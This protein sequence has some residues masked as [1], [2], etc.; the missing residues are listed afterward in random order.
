MRLL[1]VTDIRLYREGLADALA[2]MDAVDEVVTAASGASAV[3]A[4]RSGH[5]DIALVDMGTPQALGTIRAL[6][7]ARPHL[8]VVALGI[9]DDP[10][11][12]ECAAA[13]I[14][15]Y[16]S[17]DAGLATLAEAIALVGRGEAPCPGRTAAL[18]LSHI[19][20]QSRVRETVIDLTPRER[21]VLDLVR[22]GLTNRQIA[23]ALDLQL[24]TV[25]NHVHNVLGKC[26][27]ST[28]GEVIATLPG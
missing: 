22:T 1:V 23:R 20:A 26:G 15:G 19:A 27:A 2:R 10:Q 18:L 11:A 8:R 9:D 5:V 17:R 3:L 12:V 21:E 6:L 4:A 7:S 28:R 25:K 16:V 14:A 24:S 13:G